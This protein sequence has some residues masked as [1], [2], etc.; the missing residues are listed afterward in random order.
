VAVGLQHGA[1][2][3]LGA[4]AATVAVPATESNGRRRCSTPAVAQGGAGCGTRGGEIQEQARGGLGLK[5]DAARE[6]KAGAIR[7]PRRGGA[8]LR[9]VL[10]AHEVGG[11]KGSDGPRR[12]GERAWVRP[13]GR[14]E[15]RRAGGFGARWL[16]GEREES[17]M[18]RQTSENGLKVAMGRKG[19][20]KK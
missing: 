15:L 11:S 7:T 3:L 1:V 14:A 17:G 20:W 2:E 4:S 8:G 16:S 5:G 12:A 6:S 18:V 9:R 19:G 10:A 13:V